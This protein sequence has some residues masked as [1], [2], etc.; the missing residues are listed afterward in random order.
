MRRNTGNSRTSPSNA[1]RIIPFRTDPSSPS[2][3]GEKDKEKDKEKEQEKTK[4]KEKDKEKE[5][6]E[7]KDRRYFPPHHFPSH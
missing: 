7:K 2:T 5:K 4:D 6:E 1:R 3:D